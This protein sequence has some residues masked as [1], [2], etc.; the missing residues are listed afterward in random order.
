MVNANHMKDFIEHRKDNE[1]YWQYMVM[2]IVSKI[3]IQRS[4]YSRMVQDR[5]HDHS[6]HGGVS[7]KKFKLF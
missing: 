7:I 5:S 6:R 3:M 1:K 2:L 4:S